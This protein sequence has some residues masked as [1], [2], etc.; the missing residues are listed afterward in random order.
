MGG[1]HDRRARGLITGYTVRRDSD[2]CLVHRG[3]GS[4]F[5]RLPRGAL[6]RGRVESICSLAAHL[7]E[8]LVQIGRDASRGAFRPHRTGR[9][10]GLL[11]SFRRYVREA[12]GS[13]NEGIH[14]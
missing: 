11:A 5:Y 14:C 10:Q 2:D 7:S 12:E 3:R 1:R 4:W 9:R 13:M 8:T 6:R